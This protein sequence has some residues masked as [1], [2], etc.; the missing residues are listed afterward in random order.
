MKDELTRL[1][2]IVTICQEIN[3]QAQSLLVTNRHSDFT[4]GQLRMIAELSAAK[5]IVA[6][7]E[8]RQKLAEWETELMECKQMFDDRV[9]PIY[10]KET[11]NG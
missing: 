11:E 10:Q 4:L 7:R 6:N 5:S 1:F 9:Q 8:A 2:N 3:K